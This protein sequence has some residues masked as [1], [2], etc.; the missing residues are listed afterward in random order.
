MTDKQTAFHLLCKIQAS[1]ILESVPLFHLNAISPIFLFR[2]KNLSVSSLFR[3]WWNLLGSPYNAMTVLDMKKVKVHDWPNEKI[4]LRSSRPEVFCKKGVLRNSAKFI[5]KHLGQNLFFNKI[6]G[7]R[8]A[9]VNF[10]EFPRRPSLTEHLRWLLPYIM[11]ATSF[12]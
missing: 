4:I 8:H 2:D 7:L 1:E 9:T 5:G 6:A 11:Q 10:A 3:I 12:N